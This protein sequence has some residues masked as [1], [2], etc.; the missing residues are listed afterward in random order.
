MDDS[1]KEINISDVNAKI[2]RRVHLDRVSRNVLSGALF[3]FLSV[4][5]GSVWISHNEIKNSQ[6][7]NTL[8][9]DGRAVDGDITKSSVNRD[10]VYVSYTFSVDGVLCSGHAEMKADHYT[11][12]GAPEKIPIRYLP[13]DPRVNQPIYWEWFSAWD[14]F[15]FLF[16]LFIM[17]GSAAVVGVT[18]RERTL[19]RKGIVVMGRV[20]GCAPTQ[21]S[22]T[23]YYEFTTQENTE[24]E[25]SIELPDEC[26]AGTSIP[27]IYLPSNPKRNE[28]YPVGGFCIAE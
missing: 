18:L 19:A 10:G 7:R 24:M 26:G 9:R 6:I 11:V 27:I 1:L 20:T 28:R 8:L 25:G 16:L 15:P 3:F 4:L 23:V 12:P 14:M 17:A 21:K 5:G 2:P 22:F 13:R